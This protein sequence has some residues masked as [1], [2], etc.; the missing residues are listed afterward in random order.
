MAKVSL[1]SSFDE[2]RKGTSS[3]LGRISAGLTSPVE[4]DVLCN[5][6]NEI[7]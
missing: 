2:L 3:F 6:P 5:K 4:G 1:P 7:L